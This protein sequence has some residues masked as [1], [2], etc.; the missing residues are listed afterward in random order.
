MNAVAIGGCH[1]ITRAARKPNS[2]KHVTIMPRTN[3][4]RRVARTPAAVTC[5]TYRGEDGRRETKI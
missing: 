5:A 2:V 3:S 1:S 4:L